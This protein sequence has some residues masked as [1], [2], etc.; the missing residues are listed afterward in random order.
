MQAPNKKGKGKASGNKKG[1]PTTAEPAVE[2]LQLPL[3]LP[4]ADEVDAMAGPTEWSFWVLRGQVLAGAY[5]KRQHL[6]ADLLKAG[7]T[8]F[9]CLM[10]KAELERQGRPYFEGVPKLIAQAPSEYPH[11]ATRLSYRHVPIYDKGV[12]ED[13]EVNALVAEIIDMLNR[14][15]RIYLHCRGGHGRTGT[16][17]S[18]LLGR[19]YG[20]TAYEA[21][22]LCKRYHDC[23]ADVKAKPGV[24]GC[25]ETH[26]QR[27]QVYRLLSAATP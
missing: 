22:E 11:L 27:S 17:A 21:L 1:R 24:Y 5:P 13:A 9:I 23:R 3:A 14:G 15:E 25:P 2:P 8:T 16:I 12:G 20:L 10:T 6:V 19:L 26:D 18:L 7:T 4:D